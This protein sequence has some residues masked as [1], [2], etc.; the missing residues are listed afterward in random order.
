MLKSRLDSTRR[1][2]RGE[3]T[4][5]NTPGDQAEALVQD[6]AQDVCPVCTKGHADADLLGALCDQEGDYAVEADDGQEKSSRCEE[7]DEEGLESRL[8]GELAD[9]L[10]KGCDVDR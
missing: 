5:R 3:E 4:D 9:S 6:E 2:Q 1:G 7:A 8:I 10:L